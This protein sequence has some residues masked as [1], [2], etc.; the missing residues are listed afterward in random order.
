MKVCRINEKLDK[1]NVACESPDEARHAMPLI[2]TN[3]AIVNDDLAVV[4]PQAWRVA[5]DSDEEWY[6]AIPIEFASEWD[7]K[8]AM[9]ALDQAGLSS[10]AALKK[11]GH[12][13]VIRIM[14]ESLAW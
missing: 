11:A 1:M 7:A 10:S 4:G 5:L 6:H 2:V 3:L 9:F 8:R 13:T 14:M 12:D